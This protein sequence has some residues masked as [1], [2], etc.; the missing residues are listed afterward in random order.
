M[1]KKV[2]LVILV[3]VFAAIVGFAEFY[4]H[5]VSA[6]WR[7]VLPWVGWVG[8]VGSALAAISSF[9]G[10]DLRTIISI[11]KSRK[12]EQE[13]LRG[14]INDNI[15][16]AEGLVSGKERVAATRFDTSVWNDVRGKA[17]KWMRNDIYASLETAY[18]GMQ[19]MN[20]QVDYVLANPTSPHT[21]RQ[22]FHN[23]FQHHSDEILEG[24]RKAREH[25]GRGK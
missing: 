8:V 7:P 18:Q 15:R 23:A 22:I 11:R 6:G 14:E 10:Y 3:I 4:P 1:L 21:D 17:R 5:L 9:T 2:L 16:L 24:L 20:R 25:L 19:D 13:R 12:I